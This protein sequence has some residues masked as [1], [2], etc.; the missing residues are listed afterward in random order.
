MFA[1][2]SYWLFLY[3]RNHYLHS[4]II[5]GKDLSLLKYM[6]AVDQSDATILITDKEGNIEYAN[7]QLKNQRVIGLMKFLVKILEFSV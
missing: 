7:P 4:K 5:A 6:T 3:K 1:V 2:Y